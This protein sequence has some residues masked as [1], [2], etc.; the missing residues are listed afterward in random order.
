[1]KSSWKKKASAF[2]ACQGVSLFGSSITSFALVWY[3]TLK[4]GSGKW[5]AALMICSYIPQM[6]ISFVSGSWADRFSKKMLIIASDGSIAVFTLALALIVPFLS[7]DKE[8]FPLILIIAVLR[9]FFTGIQM[10]AV[11]SVIPL[12]VPKDSLMRF[13][14]INAAVQSVVQFAAPAAAGAVLSFRSLYVALFIDVVTAAIGIGI[15]IFIKVPHTSTVPSSVPSPADTSAVSDTAHMDDENDAS[16]GTDN[17]SG[18]QSAFAD[19][20]QGLTYAR[21]NSFIGILLLCYGLFIFLSCPVGFQ[22]ALYTSRTFG[23]TYWY[24]TAVEI[25]GF[26]GMALGGIVIGAWGGF[27]NR[28][29]T[30]FT[31]LALFGL[32][33]VGMGI[34]PDFIIYLVL[35][36]ILGIA[37]TMIQTA[38]TT[39]IQERTSDAMQG[40]IFGFQNIMYSGCLSLGMAVFGPL[41][42]VMSMRILIVVTGVLLA[43][44]GAAVGKTLCRK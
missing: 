10:P 13:N 42:D 20:K 31:G 38:T 21:E 39:L 28:V 1:L 37:L 6:L 33:T 29:V 43:L 30:L 19:M 35:M 9:S 40:R 4:T 22:C 11:N 27:K 36:L 12:L 34:A 44:L 2:L 17:S 14:G 15:F 8:L 7:T 26:A 32:L 24:L 3:I 16:A 5:F 41:A 18:S 23:D 25:V